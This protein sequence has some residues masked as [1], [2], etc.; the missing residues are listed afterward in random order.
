MAKLSYSQ[1]WR[2]PQPREVSSR[3]VHAFPSFPPAGPVPCPTTRPHTAHPPPAHQPR[4]ASYWRT[5]LSSCADAA[6]R[7]GGI[8]Q[9]SNYRASHLGSSGGPQAGGER[10]WASL[11]DVSL[12]GLPF[13]KDWP[14]HG[15]RPGLDSAGRRPLLN[16]NRFLC[17]RFRLVNL[18]GAR[19]NCTIAP[20]LPAGGW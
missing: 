16:W 13:A 19:T 6:R 9:Q 7:S 15:D 3:A 5:V 1:T 2:G 17:N 20:H 10:G 11:P 4:P 8:S 14:C 12:S 18:P